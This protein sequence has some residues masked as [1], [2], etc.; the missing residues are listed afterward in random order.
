MC[1]RF[2]FCELTGLEVVNST[3]KSMVSPVWSVKVI[4]QFSL[5]G[6]GW[7]T[8]VNG[9]SLVIRWFLSM[10]TWQHKNCGVPWLDLSDVSTCNTSFCLSELKKLLFHFSPGRYLWWIRTVLT[11]STPEKGWRTENEVFVSTLGL[12]S[13]HS[14]WRLGTHRGFH[15]RSYE[16]I[17]GCCHGNKQS[18]R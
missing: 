4:G 18:Q 8:C 12:R 3:C 14:Q 6:I 13:W 11:V 9:L 7:E 5:N 15:F 17:G 1:K 10:Q 2:I 16:Y